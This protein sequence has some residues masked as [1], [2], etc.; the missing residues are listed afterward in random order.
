VLTMKSHFSF[1]GMHSAIAL[2]LVSQPLFVGFIHAA[3]MAG[4]WSGAYE[5]RSGGQAA[6]YS[7]LLVVLRRGAEHLTGSAGPHE[8]EQYGIDN[9]KEAG[10]TLSFEVYRGEESN[11]YFSLSFSGDHATGKAR[12]E[13][14]SGTQIAD[15]VLDRIPNSPMVLKSEHVDLT[16]IEQIRREGLERSQVMDGAYHLTDQYGPR[17]AGSRNFKL[18]GDWLVKRLSE[19]G[20]MHIMEEPIPNPYPGWECERFTIQQ[21]EPTFAPL[22]GAPLAW[23]T[24]TPGRVSGEAVILTPTIADSRNPTNFFDRYRGRLHGKFVLIDQPQPLTLPIAPI[25]SRLTDAELLELTKAQQP[26]PPPARAARQTP[27]QPE[28]TVIELSTSWLNH[29]TGFVAQLFEFLKT[30]KVAALV[31]EGK[32]LNAGGVVR[33]MGVRTDLPAAFVM[34]SEHYNRIARLLQHAVPVRLE[35]DLSS[36]FYDSSPNSFNVIGEIPGTRKK[37]EIVMLGAHLDSW[38]AGTGATDNA[39]G[40]AIVLEALRILKRLNLKMDRTVRAA[41]WG[42]EETGPIAGST[43]YVKAHF[44]DLESR[45]MKPEYNKLSTSTAEQAR[46]A[47]PIWRVLKLPAP[48]LRLG[49]SRSRTS[50]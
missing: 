41:F 46:S 20:L 30:E 37:D 22:L 8:Y 28:N 45:S 21:L 4:D 32:R 36:R 2:L 10:E 31:Q 15:V 3:E 5:F 42:A 27:G 6:T 47:E 18:A 13:R 9:V 17:L 23:A 33:A 34:A 7:D 49:L 48:P 43:A 35:L 19:I 14:A 29:P 26:I 50:V 1:P 39:A 38:A 44:A 25:V 24:G 12:I 40:C 11:T 16:V